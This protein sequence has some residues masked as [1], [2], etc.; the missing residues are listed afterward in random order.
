MKQILRLLLCISLAIF[1]SF[2]CASNLQAQSIVVS[3]YH[4]VTAV[5]EG[6]WTELLVIQDNLTI[7]GYTLRDNSTNL[8]KW[9]GGIKFKDIPL[10]KNLRAGTT[11]V[12]NHRVF[13]NTIDKS[14]IDGYIEV[15]ANDIS[16]FDTLAVPG[17]GDWN[18]STLNLSQIADIF[19]SFSKPA[20]F[21]DARVTNVF[22]TKPDLRNLP[23]CWSRT[24]NAPAKRKSLDGA[25]VGGFVPAVCLVLLTGSG[26][27][28]FST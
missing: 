6:E 22:T 1:I 3:E 24:W 13:G 23:A 20:A 16:I 11:I 12:I 15:D 7:V 14:S 2:L 8:D 17:G 4:N 26:V 27:C 19:L 10:W 21:R 18:S 25:A 28:F 9:Q 5:P